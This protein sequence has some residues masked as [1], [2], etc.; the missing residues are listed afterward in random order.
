M[1]GIAITGALFLLVSCTKSIKDVA[2][3]K[4]KVIGYD[5]CDPATMG[6]QVLAGPVMGESF[7]NFDN[8]ISIRGL[9][10]N[11]FPIDS[12]IHIQVR[13]IKSTDDFSGICLTV[14][15][16]P[17]FSKVAKVFLSSSARPCN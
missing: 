15:R 1:K 17:V 5:F 2:C 3:L 4:V 11:Q 13:D 8:V 14:Y 12:I 10:S 9:R 6:A 7:E 16:N